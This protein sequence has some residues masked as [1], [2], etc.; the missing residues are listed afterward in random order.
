MESSPSKV[1]SLLPWPEEVQNE[2]AKVIKHAQD[3]NHAKCSAVDE[4]AQV[5][6][7]ALIAKRMLRRALSVDSERKARAQQVLAELEGTEGLR[8][9]TDCLDGM[10]EGL[11]KNCPT[12]ENDP[13]PAEPQEY[14]FLTIKFG[15]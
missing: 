9:I 1:Q 7:A 15:S 11:L 4:A 10:V 2:V 12:G 8:K 5:K 13:L 6:D 14:A 3:S